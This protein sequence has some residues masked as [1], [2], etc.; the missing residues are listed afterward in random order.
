VSHLAQGFSIICNLMTRY[1]R[2]WRKCLINQQTKSAFLIEKSIEKVA[3]K[4]CFSVFR[5]QK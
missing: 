3:L 2:F 5:A 4:T 1:N